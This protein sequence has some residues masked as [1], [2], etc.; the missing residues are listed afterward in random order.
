[1][2]IRLNDTNRVEEWSPID[3]VTF[4]F[5]KARATSVLRAIR[6][7]SDKDG[8]IDDAAAEARVVAQQI[9]GWDGIEDAEGKPL[10]FPA[11]IETRAAFIEGLPWNVYLGL[12]A[13]ILETYLAG[14]L[15][16]KD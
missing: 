4:R 15:S 7:T 16:G 10:A 13:K 3:G 9:E 8:R 6:V 1:M 12:K 14:V 2:P 5:R 11:D